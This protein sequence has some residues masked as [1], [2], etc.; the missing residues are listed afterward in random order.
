ME[1]FSSGQYQEQRKKYNVYSRI[2]LD[3]KCEECEKIHKG[4]LFLLEEIEGPEKQGSQEAVFVNI[5]KTACGHSGIKGVY[6]RN[7]KRCL[8]RNLKL[9]AEEHHGND[10]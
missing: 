4:K 9:T 2:L 5:V 3:A 8:A 7:Q 6:Q 1:R 10:T